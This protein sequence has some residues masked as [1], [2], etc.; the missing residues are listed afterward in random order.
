MLGN[1]QTEFADVFIFISSFLFLFFIS[2]ISFILLLY[3]FINIHIIYYWFSR[4]IVFI[5]TFSSLQTQT[6]ADRGLFGFITWASILSSC[7]ARV[8]YTLSGLSLSLC[9]QFFPLEPEVT[10]L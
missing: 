5:Q 6:Q 3:I 4:I 1:V 8:P 2:Y 9:C 7:T 10:T